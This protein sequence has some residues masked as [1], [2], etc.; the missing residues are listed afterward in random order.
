MTQQTST[1]PLTTA[2]G[3]HDRF[4]HLA[5]NQGGPGIVT[6]ALCGKI[7][8]PEGRGTGGF[9]ECPTCE[10]IFDRMYRL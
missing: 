4:S 9:P 2:T 6:E 5:F 7:W 10:E 3:D 1:V 8:I